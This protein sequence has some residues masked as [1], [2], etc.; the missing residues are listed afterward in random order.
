M[1]TIVTVTPNPALDVCAEVP[2]V[3]ADHKL[4]CAHAD[5]TPGGGG[6]NVARAIHRLGGA[7]TAIFPFGGSTGALLCDLLAG[8]GVPIVGVPVASTTREDF[9][10]RET[11]TGH[12]YRFVLPGLPLDPSEV[13]RCIEEVVQHAHAG[14]FVV[15]S[16]SMPPGVDTDAIE[17]IVGP[18]RAAGSHL[19]VDTSGPA[20]TTFAR[21]GVHLLK[22]SLHE[23]VNHAGR[24]LTAMDDIIDA[25]NDLRRSGPNIAV[26]VSLGADG[27]VLVTDSQPPCIVETPPIP[28]VSAVG[29]GDSL[30][31]GLVLGLA[32]GEALIDATRRG[33]AAGSAAT[34]SA[35]HH[36]CR[37]PDVELLLP[38]VRATPLETGRIAA[39]P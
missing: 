3:E 19:V 11:T 16:G 36:L 12:E 27:A 10:V 33:V 38:D 5:R 34:M 25:A 23:L 22:P 32:H 18:L 17:A 15:I 28:V 9:S 37:A 31:A 20:L 39:S 6:I 24:E 4:H 35:G 13:A 1:T 26:V 29:A 7:A 8:E 30:V 14:S 2:T 21:L